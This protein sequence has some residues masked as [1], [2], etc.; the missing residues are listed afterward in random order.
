[1]SR[2][3]KINRR[4]FIG[5]ASCAAVGSTTFFSTLF[6]LGMANEAA[7]RANSIVSSNG[8]YKALVCI[9][10]G[11][12]NDSYN[13]LV[14]MDN[15]AYQEYTITRSN[16]ALAKNTLL[17]LSPLAGN[18]QPLGFHP[19]MPEVQQLFNSGRLSVIANIGT[20]IEPTTTTN[21]FSGSAKL[22]LG[23][24]SHADQIQQWQTSV[25]Q[26]RNANGWGGRVADILQS[27]NTNQNISMSISLA[28]RNV[29]QSGNRTSEYTIRPDGNGSIGIDGY[30][31]EGFYQQVRRS[32]I[33]SLLEQQYSDIFTKTYADVIRNAQDS[34]ELFSGAVGQV[35][36]GTTF[37]ETYLS[38][39]LQMVAKTIAARN[40]LGVSR[41]TFFVSYDGWDHH[42]ELLN[43]QSTML[44]E[45]SQAFGEF[46]AALEELGLANDVTT[47]TI[48]DFARTLTSNGNGTDH[49]WGGNVMVMGGAVQGGQVYGEY[50]SL[51]LNSALE[52]GNGVLVPTLSTDEYFA[53]LASWFG[54]SNGDLSNIFPNLTNFYV[55]GATPPIGF[56]K[57]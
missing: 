44:R 34:H 23:L 17:P 36:L 49:G 22:P 4:K 39:S 26:S 5:Q 18:Q 48:S 25:P 43:A 52:I 53:E 57:A 40:T 6:N 10:F 54:V 19:S 56:M 27:M 15:A 29:F 21:V 1:M 16:Q 46:N 51:G 38:Q 12:G 33:D 14:P 55:P 35:N 20:L 3:H 11:G 47:F 13:M 30:E 42:D 2:K 45:V 8:N 41:Q 28:G 31:E 9:L 32:A 50:P 24:F 7:A 37:S